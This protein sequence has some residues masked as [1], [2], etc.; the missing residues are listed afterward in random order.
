MMSKV[1][2][3][4]VGTPEDMGMRFIDAWKRAEQ[5]EVV[6][7]THLTFLDLESLLAALTP[8]RLELLR[9]VRHHD[10]ATVK[11]LAG[12]LH[13]DYKNV[14]QDVDALT[15]LGLIAKT[16]QGVTAPYGE[17]EARIVL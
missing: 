5:G 1:I 12:D 11:A 7:E 14:H 17:V 10:V 2:N 13:R 9:Y 8:R 3:L 4:H 15:R 16:A 6:D